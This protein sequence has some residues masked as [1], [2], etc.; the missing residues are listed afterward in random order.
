[1]GV[2][3]IGT[4][5]EDAELNCMFETYNV[6]KAACFVVTVDEQVKGCAA[7]GPLPKCAPATCELQKMYF[8][9]SLR[10]KGIGKKMLQICLKYAKRTGYRECYLETMTY[11]KAAQSMYKKAGFTYLKQA[12]G[13]TGHYECSVWML[14]KL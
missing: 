6:K 7:I 2:P 13:N 12:M 14:K 3:K 1:M 4:T 11:M 8:A 10:G 5:Y 9:P